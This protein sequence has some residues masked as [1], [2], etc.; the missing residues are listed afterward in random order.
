MPAKTTSPRRLGLVV[1]AAVLAGALSA[2]LPVGDAHAFTVG[3]Q[4]TL[5]PGS[6][7]PVDFPGRSYDLGGKVPRGHV[8]L[9]R[10]VEVARS[11]GRRGLSFLCP[12]G[13]YAYSPS[14]VEGASI[15]LDIPDVSQYQKKLRRFR[16]RVYASPLAKRDPAVSSVYLL[17]RPRR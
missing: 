15:G 6:R 17:C 13:T 2:L 14:L 11:E 8:M 1:A 12:G 4:Q 16:L 7:M 10:R 5:G 9:R 3:T